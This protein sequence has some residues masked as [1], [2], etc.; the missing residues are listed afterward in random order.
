[1]AATPL[2]TLVLL[3]QWRKFLH[4]ERSRLIREGVRAGRKAMSAASKAC[5]AA[6]EAYL[7]EGYKVLHNRSVGC[8]RSKK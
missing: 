1:M 4:A 8:I 5:A 6:D 3:S 7:T 2:S